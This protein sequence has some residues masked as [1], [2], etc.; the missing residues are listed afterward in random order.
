MDFYCAEL[1][2]AI[3]IDG[4]AHRIAEAAR[5]DAWR[6]KWLEDEGIRFFRVSSRRV[7]H[8]LEAFLAGLAI[9]LGP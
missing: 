2:V 5:Q 9:E 6:Q 1:K 3:E 8:D 4:G 7:E